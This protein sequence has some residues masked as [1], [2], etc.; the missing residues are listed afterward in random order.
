M[1]KKTYVVHT[2][3]CP[4]KQGKESVKIS[5]CNE[6]VKYALRRI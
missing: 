3:E 2:N 1:Q 5:K 4:K 6:F